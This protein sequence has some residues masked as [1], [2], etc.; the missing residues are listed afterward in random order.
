MGGR[1]EKQQRAVADRVARPALSVGL[2]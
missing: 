1:Q 2:S